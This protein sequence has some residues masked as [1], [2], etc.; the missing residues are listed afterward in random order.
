V[1]ATIAACD[2]R[3][4]TTIAATPSGEQVDAPPKAPPPACRKARFDAP[5]TAFEVVHL[6]SDGTPKRLGPPPP[7]EPGATMVLVYADFGPPAMAHELLGTAWWSWEGGGSFEAGD[8]FDVRVVV[9]QKRTQAQVEA[10]YP[11][12]KG[13]SDYRVVN[14][15]DA[16][17]Y[18]DEHVVEVAQMMADEPELDLRSLQADLERTRALIRECLP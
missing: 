9:Y 11:T 2:R 15:V 1:C 13:K 3:D 18:L 4:T 12:V 16:L 6:N 17:K 7:D 8:A 10:R 5:L 14:K